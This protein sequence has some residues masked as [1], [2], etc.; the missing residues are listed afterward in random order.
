MAIRKKKRDYDEE[1]KPGRLEQMSIRFKDLLYFLSYGIW[2]Q[3]PETISNKKNILYDAIKTV[4]L[5]VR[6]AQELNIAASARSLTYR[7][8]L[9]IVPLLAVIFA[10]ARGFGFE[11]IMESSIF[12]FMLGDTPAKEVEAYVSPELDADSMTVFIDSVTGA[13]SDNEAVVDKDVRP[14][15]RMRMPRWINVRVSF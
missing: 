13:H 7:T 11:N 14:R 9:S 1:I 2:R 4:I 15:R 6:N 8:L 12:S 10:I 3:N 5:T